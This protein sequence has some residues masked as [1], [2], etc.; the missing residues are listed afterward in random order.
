MTQ[1]ERK[2]EIYEIPGKFVK[3][4]RLTSHDAFKYSFRLP[5]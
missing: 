3:L 1:V 4:S 5:I 2:S